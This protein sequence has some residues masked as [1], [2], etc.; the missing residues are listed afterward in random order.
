ME[1]VDVPINII[2]ELNDLNELNN[3]NTGNEASGGIS[4]WV[5]YTIIVLV[6]I[7]VVGLVF[8][9]VKK[10]NNKKR[11]SG[12]IIQEV[13]QIL[14][15]DVDKKVA[16]NL[17]DVAIRARTE[18]AQLE[19]NSETSVQ[20]ATIGKLSQS[21]ADAAIKAA[22]DAK[23]K[24]E[25]AN[26]EAA[27]AI[28]SIRKQE[29]DNANKAVAEATAVAASAA[30]MYTSQSSDIIDEKLKEAEE[31]YAQ[32]VKQRELVENEYKA[33]LATRRQAE[34]NAYNNKVEQANE[35]IK[36]VKQIQD[37]LKTVDEKIKES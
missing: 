18:Q 32:V 15:E 8:F 11:E 17:L 22:A 14:T 23:I 33:S 30:V 2:G 13:S 25:Q 10:I 37:K 5:I 35:T 6:I 29:L 16:N 21:D 26:I 7:A 27:K 31:V 19:A 34:R 1:N 28:E 3:V 9:I 4:R 24:A 36:T 20:L 12:K